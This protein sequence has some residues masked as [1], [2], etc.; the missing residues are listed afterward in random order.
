MTANTGRSRMRAALLAT[1]G[2]L[3]A[4]A[5]LSRLDTDADSSDAGG[6]PVYEAF[7]AY[8]SGFAQASAVLTGTTPPRSFLVRFFV[9]IVPHGL[10]HQ[11]SSVITVTRARIAG[12]FPA[13]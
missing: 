2:F 5:L 8:A 7:S 12:R 1:L 10:R 11:C 4:L 3:M 13:F 9:L 6:S